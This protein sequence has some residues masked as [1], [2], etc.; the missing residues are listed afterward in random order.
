MVITHNV[1]IWLRGS[2]AAVVS[3][4]FWW[5]AALAVVYLFCSGFARL[6][7]GPSRVIQQ[8]PMNQP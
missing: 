2:M 6:I 5:V 1:K 8:A 7:D 3:R 4:I